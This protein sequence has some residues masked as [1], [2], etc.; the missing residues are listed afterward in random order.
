MDTFLKVFGALFIISGIIGGMLIYDGDLTEEYNIYK[1]LPSIYE[2]QVEVLK[3]L[4]TENIVNTSMFIG[5]GVISGVFF[6]ALGFILEQLMISNGLDK[7]ETKEGKVSF[8][9]KLTKH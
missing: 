5:G 4:Q 9:D 7:R 6:M 3:P 2:E 8:L 1:D